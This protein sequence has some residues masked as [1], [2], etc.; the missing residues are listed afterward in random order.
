MNKIEQLKRIVSK[1]RSIRPDLVDYDAETLPKN[2]VI[3]QLV[4]VKAGLVETRVIF[5]GTSW[6][7]VDPKYL[8]I[9]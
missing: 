3:G 5:D 1:Y 7:V 8:Q 4:V 6:N 2:P 9:P